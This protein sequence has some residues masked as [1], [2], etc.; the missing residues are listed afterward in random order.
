[1]VKKRIPFQV[2]I[3]LV[4]LLTIALVIASG[5]LAYK[6]LTDIVSSIIKETEP[7][8][9]LLLLNEIQANLSYAESSVKTYSITKN[10]THLIPYYN[11]VLSIHSKINELYKLSLQNTP[12]QLA[13]IDS[14]N[15]LTEEKVLILNSLINM[16]EN[17]RVKLALNRLS[18]KIKVRPE[19]RKTILRKQLFLTSCLRRKQKKKCRRKKCGNK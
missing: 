8:K 3:L 15:A 19:K 6:S 10:E 14:V 13:I 1:M 9:K 7:D 2:N 16:T 4:I 5:T 17:N 18:E 11:A 12:A